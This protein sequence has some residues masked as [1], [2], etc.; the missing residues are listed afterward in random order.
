MGV[1][2]G[3]EQGGW[4]LAIG[5]QRTGSGRLPFARESLVKELLVLVE[6]WCVWSVSQASQACLSMIS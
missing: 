6:L 1:I 5:D 4:S 2:E 3:G